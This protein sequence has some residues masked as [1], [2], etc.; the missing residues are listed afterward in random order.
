[1]WHTHVV[2]Q[3][4]SMHA[5]TLTHV[6]LTLTSESGLGFKS[7]VYILKNDHSSYVYILRDAFCI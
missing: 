2:G 4:L 5:K 3:D 1:M 7:F 6:A